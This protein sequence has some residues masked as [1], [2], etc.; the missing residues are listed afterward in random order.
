MPCACVYNDRKI[1][2]KQLWSLLH[3]I[4]VMLNNLQKIHQ[5]VDFIQNFYLA[6]PCEECHKHCKEYMEKN[7]IVLT[8]LNNLESCKK[9]IAKFLYDFHNHVNSFTQKEIFTNFEDYQ[10]TQPPRPDFAEI[11]KVFDNPV[12]KSF[13]NK[14]LTPLQR[15]YNYNL[16]NTYIRFGQ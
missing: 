4:P 1:W 11:K 5:V 15:Q 8:D 9:D 3:H 2:G 6:L 10:K 7:K 16:I 14:F 13:F 12:N